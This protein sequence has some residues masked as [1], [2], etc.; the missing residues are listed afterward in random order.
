MDEEVP[1]FIE[2]GGYFLTEA[3]IAA[4][5]FMHE[6]RAYG[7]PERMWGTLRVLDTL[8]LYRL[9]SKCGRLFHATCNGDRVVMLHAT[10]PCVGFALPMQQEN[11]H[12]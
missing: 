5:Q 1:V 12:G 4:L 9:V 6:K 8:W 10:A 3:E 2:V 7:V 11:V